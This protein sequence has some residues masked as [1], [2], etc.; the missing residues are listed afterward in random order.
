M[1]SN[2]WLRL[3]RSLVVLAA[4]LALTFMGCTEVDDSL[5]SDFIPQSQQ[6]RLGHRTLTN[7]FDT[8]LYQTDS[9]RSSNLEVA[10]LGST[11]SDTFGVRSAGFYTQYTWGYCPDSTDGFGYRPIFDSILL[12]VVVNN[13]GG[14]TTV[15]RRYEVYEVV[16]DQF[17]YEDQYADTTFYGSFDMTPYLSE[18][19]AFTF[20]FP[21]QA[22]GIYTT[23]IGVKM[24]PTETGRDLVE[25]LMLLK[26][27]Y[28]E[29]KMEG[30][31]NPADWVKHFKGV[32]IKPA[33]EAQS[34]AENSIYEFDLTEMG[35]VLYGRNRNEVDPT[36]I[37]DTT[38]SIY[39]FLNT[40]STAG[41]VSINTFRHNYAGS[42]LA[43][44]R[45]E[46]TETER[47]L[48]PTCLAEGMAGVV[49]EL[50]AREELFEQLAAILEE[51]CD[52]AGNHYSSLAINQ[53]LLS[54][55]D[56][57]G[58]Y[59]WE[60]LPISE[61]MIWRLEESMPRLGLYSTYKRTDK[62]TLSGV[63]DYAYA[64]E[65]TYGTPLNFGGY[66]NRS[67]A[68]Y[69][70]DISMYLQ[71]IW[72]KYLEQ[73]AEDP[74]LSPSEVLSQMDQKAICSY[75][76]PEAYALNTFR[77]M[78]GQGMVDEGNNAPMRIELTYTLIK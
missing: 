57:E 55:Y 78:S 74:S 58:D 21:N 61:A 39:Y 71:T 36:L 68:C 29:N 6:L 56:V 25:R 17:L 44:K 14:D 75:L 37:Q 3:L 49:T 10:L 69:A 72:N 16:D 9:I 45:F 30:F 41:N 51:E 54:I 31:Y 66:L 2:L 18:E 40:E 19:P 47:S 32:Y 43:D 59:N 26:G 52:E 8:R 60:Q 34:Q 35:L 20:E 12:G 67:R 50:V 65:Q 62:K 22:K 5:G 11:I 42:W 48:T 73:Q 46:E 27:A 1:H 28:A 7:C 77:T 38:I 70:L 24:Q 63:P 4:V 15:V 53:A 23:S 64:Y 76:G 33:E 13:Y